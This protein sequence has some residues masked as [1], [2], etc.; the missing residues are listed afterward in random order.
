MIG[1]EERWDKVIERQEDMLG[2][3][4]SATLSGLRLG[5]ERQLEF[6]PT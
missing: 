5:E 4:E 1:E 6:T 3:V 2:N